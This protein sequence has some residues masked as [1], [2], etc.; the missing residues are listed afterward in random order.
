MEK[1]LKKRHIINMKNGKRLIN[2]IMKGL[3]R[4]RILLNCL[5]FIYSCSSNINLKNEL[6]LNFWLFDNTVLQGL[7]LNYVDSVKWNSKERIVNIEYENIDD[8]T[9]IYTLGYCI[10]I[11][12]LIY[13]HPQLFLGVEGI[14]VSISVKGFKDF[15]LSQESIN[16]MIKLH[17][18]EQYEYII[19]YGELPP[20]VTEKKIFWKITVQNEKIIDREI[21]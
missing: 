8:S 1:L 9:K 21:Y 3:I 11:N 17:F 6:N 2:I 18:P 4:Q 14:L 13:N 5:W 10:D 12:D 15:Q 19:K 16:R 7:I 20:P